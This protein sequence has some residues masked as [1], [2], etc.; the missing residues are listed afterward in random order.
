MLNIISLRISKELSF[1][2]PDLAR[3]LLHLGDKTDGGYVVS[4]KSI[5]ATKNLVSYGLGDNFS[6]E[7]DFQLLSLQHSNRI[8][9]DIYDFS[10]EKPSFRKLFKLV[11]RK[12][13]Q[14]KT[15]WFDKYLLWLGSYRNFFR[16]DSAQHHK[17]KIVG[18]ANKSLDISAMDTLP[19]GNLKDTFLKIDIE[20]GEY[21][22]LESL[23]EHFDGFTGM[24]IE[25][26]AVGNNIEKFKD[27]ILEIR[28]L[29]DLIYV[30]VNNYGLISKSGIPE[31]LEISFVRK[32]LNEAKGV[33]IHEPNDNWN[34][35][36]CIS[37]PIYEISWI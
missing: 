24:V 22:V 3:N 15:K 16:N 21:G 28:K 11:F 27:I 25:F 14:S 32:D 6:F 18:F 9:V 17:R 20:G 31:V 5:E 33:T 26:H 29:H 34:F 8:N 30:H 13:I 2:K 4:T 36:N 23:K 19:I 12:L 37:G 1:L 10:V 35:P 7:K